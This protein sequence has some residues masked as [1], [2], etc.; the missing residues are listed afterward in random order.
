MKESEKIVSFVTGFAGYPLLEILWRGHT[1]WSMAWAGGIV[2]FLLY[3]F[4]NKKTLRFCMRAALVI[5]LIE[6]IFGLIFNLIFKANV[7]DYSKL[8]G[9]LWGQ[10]CLPFSCLWFLLGVPLR[11]IC[12]AINKL[13]KDLD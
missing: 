10:I 5:T 8:R 4:A 7:W 2:L 3:P 1:H 6:L 13:C 12:R 9:N 11:L